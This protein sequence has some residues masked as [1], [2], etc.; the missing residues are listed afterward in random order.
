MGFGFLLRSQEDFERF[1]IAINEGA[2]T[3][4]DN[5][6]FSGM[7]KKPNYQDPVGQVLDNGFENFDLPGQAEDI[8]E[9]D[10]FVLL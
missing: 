10:D 5:W 3:F 6:V 2:K 1:R 9:S 4:G 8:E 7:D